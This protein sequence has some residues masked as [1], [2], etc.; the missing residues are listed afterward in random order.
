MIAPVAPDFAGTVLEL[1]AGIGS[2]TVRLA[3]RCPHAKILACEINPILAQDARS[4]L[5]RAGTNGQ[6]QIVATSAQQLIAHLGSR[7]GPRP[8]YVISGLPLGNLGRKTVIALIDA[9]RELLPAQGMFIQA[10]HFLVDRK[11]IQAAFPNLRTA[12]IMLNVLPV[13]IYFA[14]KTESA[15]RTQTAS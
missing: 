2:L 12:W 5:A 6:V 8:T 9:I 7:P 11:R 10:Q 15:L 13:F 4:N 1:G 14:E 3:A